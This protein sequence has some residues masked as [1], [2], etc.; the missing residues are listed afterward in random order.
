MPEH[1]FFKLRSQEPHGYTREHHVL[2]RTFQIQ[3]FGLDFTWARKHEEVD[4]IIS[5]ISCLFSLPESISRQAAFRNLEFQV[6]Q[7]TYLARLSRGTQ[8]LLE[9]IDQ[10]EDWKFGETFMNYRGQQIRGKS[11]SLFVSGPVTILIFETRC[12]LICFGCYLLLSQ[13][14]KA[15]AL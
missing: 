1:I 3:N 8:L 7:C 14:G 4:I 10:N 13:L 12:W 9:C 6:K 11:A 5:L 2:G 15:V